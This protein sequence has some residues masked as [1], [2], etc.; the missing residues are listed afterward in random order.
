MWKIRE[1]KVVLF[2]SMDERDDREA[3]KI[4]RSSK[5]K[6]R[7]SVGML[8]QKGVLPMVETIDGGRII[9]HRGLKGMKEFLNYLC[10]IY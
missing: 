9:H 1:R 5:I 6:F 3:M 7:I 10:A 4:L 2:I 8:Y